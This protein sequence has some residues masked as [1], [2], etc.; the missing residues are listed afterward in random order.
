MTGTA[1]LLPALF[2]A[3][4]VLGGGGSSNRARR[5]LRGLGV[6]HSS[7]GVGNGSL[8]QTDRSR[9]PQPDPSRR[10]ELDQWASARLLITSGAVA[11]PVLHF[12]VGVA[13]LLPAI[14]AVGLLAA[15]HRRSKRRPAVGV[16]EAALFAELLAAHLGSG[17]AMPPA[18]RRAGAIGPVLTTLSREVGNALSAGLTPDEAWAPAR[19]EP[20]LEGVMRICTRSAATGS[21]CSDELLRLARR[22]RHRHE[23]ELERRAERAG[24]WLVLPLGACFLPAFVL[25]TVVPVVAGLLP[26]LP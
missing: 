1:V 14:G 19:A 2:A 8:P 24:I 11:V 23:Q 21:G 7:P 15:R 22:M 18:L 16:G 20:A 4:A 3:A 5:R 9:R 12:T 26:N 13:G 10:H 25:L 6:R 17:T